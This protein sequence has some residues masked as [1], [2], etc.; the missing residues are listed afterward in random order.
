MKNRFHL[1]KPAR[2]S[3]HVVFFYPRQLMYLPILNRFLIPLDGQTLHPLVAPAH[4]GQQSP[5]PAWAHNVHGTI[6]RSH[7]QSDPASSNPPHTHERML[8]SATRVPAFESAVS[9]GNFVFQVLACSF[10]SDVSLPVA[11]DGRCAQ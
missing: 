6:P 9:T 7:A 2:L 4:A 5:D 1:P 10:S 8:L 11:S 3:V